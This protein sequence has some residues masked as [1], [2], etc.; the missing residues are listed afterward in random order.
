MGTIRNERILI[1]A[2]TYPYPSK[3]YRETSCIAGVGGNGKLV[4]L[5]PVPYRYMQ[6]EREFQK[7][8]YI[9][10]RISKAPKD[11]RP[12]SHNIDQDS[13]VPE[14]VISTNDGWADRIPILE[15]HV[16]SDPASLEQKRQTEAATLGV[17]KPIEL[18][19]LLITPAKNPNW[20]PQEQANLEQDFLFDSVE[21]KKHITLRKLPY[22]FRYRYICDTPTGRREFSH[23]ITDWE[24][25]ALY[26]NLRRSHGDAWEGHFRQRLEEQFRD[27]KQLYFLL[28]TMHRFPDQ[29][30]IV[31]FY[32]PPKATSTSPQQTTL[33]L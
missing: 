28:G 26:W 14:E 33:G 4:R 19:E 25:G 13:I 16:H 9:S 11:H 8:Q 27:S 6:G 20:T 5:F 18:Q 3:K 29:W 2:K 15:K 7:W 31:A 22:E 10:A 24:V 12:E 30:L 32:Y 17:I 1:L 23:M 21:L